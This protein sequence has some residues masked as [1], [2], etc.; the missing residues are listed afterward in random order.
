MLFTSV[1]CGN[2]KS[3]HSIQKKDKGKTA[4]QELMRQIV[5]ETC[6]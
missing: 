4:Q 6:Q 2:E 3:T 1:R 5:I